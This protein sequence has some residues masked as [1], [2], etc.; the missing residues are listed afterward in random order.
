MKTLQSEW[1]EYLK[2]ALP[3]LEAGAPRVEWRDAFYAGAFAMQRFSVSSSLIPRC[4]QR[5][6][7]PNTQ[8]IPHPLAAGLFICRNRF[9]KPMKL[10]AA[11]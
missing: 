3:A 10:W 6:I 8:S 7:Q 11:S 1:R 5:I 4:L 9:Q 2:T